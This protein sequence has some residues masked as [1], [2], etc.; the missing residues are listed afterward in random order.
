[1]DQV[2]VYFLKMNNGENLLCTLIEDDEERIHITQ[3]Y[4][5]E[6]M[7]MQDSMTVTT[8][9]MK[10]IPFDS[11]MSKTISIDKKNVLTYMI[12]DDIVATKYNNTISEHAK[13]ESELRAEQI[14]SLLMQ[15]V[16]RRIANTSFSGIH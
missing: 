16:L 4:R 11:I 1:M 5:V 7:Q 6:M 2:E 12:V 15:N 13:R 10:W 8:A 14:R 9:I 3:P